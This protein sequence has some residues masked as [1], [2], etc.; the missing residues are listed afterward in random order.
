MFTS[1]ML[2]TST[3]AALFE[4]MRGTTKRGPRARATLKIQ[5]TWRKKHGYKT[6]SP[7]DAGQKTKKRR[8]RRRSK[9]KRRKHGRKH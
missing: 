3:S 5:K 8:R 1:F 4:P 7:G 9:H 6:P 2:R